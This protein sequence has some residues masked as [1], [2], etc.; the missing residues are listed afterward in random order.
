MVL[1]KIIK[2][3]R[4]FVCLIGLISICPLLILAGSII[5]IEDGFPIFFV[6]ERIGIHKNTFKIIKI[7]TLK[8]NT[9]NI[10][11][12]ELKKSNMLKN[13]KWIRKIKLDEF[14]QL[15]NVL[16][17]DLNIVGPRP[18]LISQGI[19]LEERSLKNVFMV[20]PGITGLAQILGYDMSDPKK[21]AEI[22][23]LY[24]INKSIVIDFLIIAGTFFNYPKQ[25]LKKRLNIC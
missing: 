18:G 2:L 11:T 8:K 4:N 19:L 25:N 21:L 7:R 24:I 3:F 15:I 20:K 10:G 14:P 22:D 12:H 5:L 9:P 6:Q 23:E 13:G 17:G 1:K 16:K